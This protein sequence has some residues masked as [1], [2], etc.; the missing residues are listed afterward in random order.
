MTV[1]T[2]IF[3]RWLAPNDEW[4]LL[5]DSNAHR[6]GKNAAFSMPHERAL[7]F[8]RDAHEL[9]HGLPIRFEFQIINPELLHGALLIAE[10]NGAIESVV[11]SDDERLQ[12]KIAYQR[13][14]GECAVL[15]AAKGHDAVIY[16]LPFIFRRDLFELCALCCPV[17]LGVLD[18]NGLACGTDTLVVECDR[19]LRLQHDTLATS[20]HITPLYLTRDRYEKF[21]AQVLDPRPK[22][23]PRGN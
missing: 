20:P 13:E 12:P 23:S 21:S 16:S 22:C 14:R 5:F 17:D 9:L 2:D 7:A 10:Y 6:I 4:H 1:I 19:V 3:R 8:K 18:L 15:A 11:E